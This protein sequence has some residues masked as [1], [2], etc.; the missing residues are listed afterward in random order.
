MKSDLNYFIHESS[1]IDE[2]VS[3]GEGTKIWHFSHIQSGA[4]IGRNCSL[5]QNVNISNNV[6][7]GNNVKI[8]NNVSVYEG[9]EL[10]DY[11]FCGPSMVFTNI[12]LPRSEF[13]QRDAELYLKTLVKKSASIGANAT[14]LCG[15]TIGEYAI[16]GSGS[17]VT[18]DVPP[19]SLVV[20]NPGKIIGKVNEKGERA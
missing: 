12:K 14:I 5:G 8:Q 6:K 4:K 13:P 11:V 3:I 9:V 20:G 19:F 17:V 10:E 16:I 2:G 7:I 18:K 15:I 1:Y